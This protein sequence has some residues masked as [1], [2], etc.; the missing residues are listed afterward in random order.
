ML[1]VLAECPICRNGLIGIRRCSD[2]STLVLMCDECESVWADPA[3][4][5]G[6]AEFTHYRN[7]EVT[8]REPATEVFQ[9]MDLSLF[10]ADMGWLPAVIDGKYAP[11]CGVW[12]VE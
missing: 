8:L 6:G 9:I 10:Y 12:D 11:A 3:P 5:G 1:I 2:G 4:A 7:A